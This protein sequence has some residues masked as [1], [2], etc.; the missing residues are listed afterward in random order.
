MIVTYDRRNNF[1]VQATGAAV[2]TVQFLRDVPMGP[3]S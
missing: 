2:T 1:I 3:M